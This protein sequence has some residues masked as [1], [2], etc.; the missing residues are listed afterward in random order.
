MTELNNHNLYIFQV[1]SSSIPKPPYL[2]VAYAYAAQM[3]MI[4]ASVRYGRYI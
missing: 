2:Y 4:D 1:Y 3:V